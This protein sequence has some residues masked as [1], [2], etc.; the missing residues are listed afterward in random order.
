[1]MRIEKTHIFFVPGLAANPMIF[2]FIDLPKDKFEMHYLEWL[3]PE[4]KNES[5]ENY[6]KRMCQSIECK[7]PVLIGV[8][9][10]GVMVQE[11]KK[12]CNPQKTILISSIK[13]KF[14]MPIRM[15]FAQKTK[16]HKLLPTKALTN[17]EKYEKFA[18]GN[19]LKG[20][21]KLYKK[22]LSMNDELYLPWA[23]D[24]IVNWNK[25][26]TDQDIIHIHGTKDF[27]FPIEN[28]K[29]CIEVAGGTHAMILTK[30]KIISDILK[31]QI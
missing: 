1:M 12:I 26:T 3:V 5:I 29:N 2:D 9:F 22:Y 30:A 6:A 21:V 10:G 27:I 4:N 15:R 23:I 20:K 25:E 19:M 31:E 17:I 28:I 11:M 18:F 16:A 13:N 14:E 7:N 8:S 24:T